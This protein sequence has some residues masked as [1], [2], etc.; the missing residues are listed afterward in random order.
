MSSGRTEWDDLELSWSRT[1]LLL[2]VHLI[3][4][5]LHPG[6]EPVRGQNKVSASSLEPSFRGGRGDARG[7]S[8]SELPRPGGFLS[9]LRVV[10]SSGLH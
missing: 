5:N 3:S 10:E 6:K 9:G 4:P 1:Q 2:S 7:F 8:A